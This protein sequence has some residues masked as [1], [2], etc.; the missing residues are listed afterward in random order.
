MPPIVPKVV[1]VHHR[2][3]FAQEHLPNG[4]PAFVN[5]FDVI[6]EPVIVGYAPILAVFLEL[7]EMAVGP[8]HERLECQRHFAV[9]RLPAP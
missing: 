8:S 9:T 7:V 1:D 2:I 6:L 5:D 3:A 4:H